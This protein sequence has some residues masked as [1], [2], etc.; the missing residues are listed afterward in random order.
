MGSSSPNGFGLYDMSG[1]VWEWC[2]N[3]F[4]PLSYFLNVNGPGVGAE[5]VVRGGSWA[6]KKELIP[7]Y[8]RGSQPPSWCTPYTGFRVV[9]VKE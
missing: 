8:T 7:L 6:N 4:S 9:L 2:E 3:W 1:N 5:K